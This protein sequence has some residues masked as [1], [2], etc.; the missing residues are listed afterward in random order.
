MLNSGPP[1]PQKI[2][3]KSQSLPVWNLAITFNE[4]NNSYDRTVNPIEHVYAFCLI[5]SFNV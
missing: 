3:R 5:R 4:K 1:I 2:N